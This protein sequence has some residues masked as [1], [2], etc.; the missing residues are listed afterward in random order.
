[1]KKIFLKTRSSEFENEIKQIMKIKKTL[2]K[3][4]N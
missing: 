4:M 1:M 3:E 2:K